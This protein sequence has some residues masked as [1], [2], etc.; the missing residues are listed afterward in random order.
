MVLFSAISLGA[1]VTDYSEKALY[2]SPAALLKGVKSPF[3]IMHF[4]KDK[5]ISP[6][7]SANIYNAA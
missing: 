5:L 6:E 7:Q 4:S 2:A 3:L 1:S